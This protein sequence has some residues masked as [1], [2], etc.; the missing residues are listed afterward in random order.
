MMVELRKND[1]SVLETVETG[2]VEVTDIIGWHV[3]DLRGVNDELDSDV[4]EIAIQV[5]ENEH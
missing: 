4:A 2:S 3:D 5:P 1:G